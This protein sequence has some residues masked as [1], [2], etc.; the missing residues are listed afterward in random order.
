MSYPRFLFSR[1]RG[2]RGA[3]RTRFV[4]SSPQFPPAY[5]YDQIS[6]YA[7]LGHKYQIDTLFA[8][9]LD[10][11]KLYFT[12]DFATWT[13]PW[14]HRYPY[15]FSLMHAIGVVDLAHLLGCSSLLPTAFLV[16]C[17][18]RP[19]DLLVGLRRPDGS[20]MTLSQAD[21]ARVMSAQGTLVKELHA[22]LVRVCSACVHSC[23]HCAAV[24]DEILLACIDTSTRA[25]D[26]FVECD[27]FLYPSSGRESMCTACEEQFKA[28]MRIQ[29][30]EIWKRLPEIFDVEVDGWA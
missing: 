9:A 29:Q 30:R 19:Q 7:R 23:A 4:H 17:F 24:A 11:L 14:I 12:T 8:Q 15:K 3:E 20:F 10:Y 21:L 26:P 6:A 27:M 16:C 28:R 22:A 13:R 2:P 5:T 25:L 18:I 1:P